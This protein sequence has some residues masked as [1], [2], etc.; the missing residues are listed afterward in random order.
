MVF[1]EKEHLKGDI[2]GGINAGIVALPAALGF[3]ALA[4]L[5]PIHGLYC[6]IF[7]GLFAAI[8]GGTKTLISNPTGPMAVVTYG[9][10]VQ[11]GLM[12]DIPESTTALDKIDIIWPYLFFVFFIAGG[13]QLLFSF[14]KLGKYISYIPTPVV[15]GFMSGIGIIIIVSQIPKALG[16]TLPVRG[17]GGILM[18]L[19]NLILDADI[20]TV[21]IALS[22][23]AIIYLFPKITKKVPGPLVAIVIVT[24]AVYFI[25]VDTD[26]YLIPPIPQQLPNALLQGTLFE[27]F[28]SLF[29]G[30]GKEGMLMFVILSGLT[31]SIIG[32]IDALL[33]AVVSDQ[34]TKT[35]HNSNRELLGQGVGNMVSAMFGGM[36][37]AGTTPATV[38]NIKSGGRS[39]MSGIIHAVLLIAILL[40]AAP[41][42][43]MIPKAALAGLL[44]TVGISILDFDVFKVIKKLPLQDNYVMFMVLGMTAFWDLMYAV[45]AGL[46]FAALVF[47]KK[48]ADAVEIDTRNSKVDRLVDQLVDSFSDS[49]EFRKHVHIKNIKGPMFF[50]FASRFQ[51][52]IEEVGDVK[53]V[54]LN[55]GASTYM[56]QSGVYTLRE[57]IQRLKDKNVTVVL[58]EVKEHAMGLLR[59][60]GVVPQLVDENHV[61]SSV[62]ECVMWLRE[63]GHL[64][65]VFEDDGKLYIPPAYTPNGDGINDEW[66]IRHI[67]K[68]PTCIVDIYTREQKHVFSSKGY[69]EMWEGE[70]EGKTLPS[71]TYHYVIDLYGDG[72]DVR[73]G[74]V[75][76]FR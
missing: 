12:L 43:S 21:V 11:L 41:V 48:M 62:E 65:D 22:T 26:K 61:F 39:R 63:P 35:K 5:S 69:K 33:T 55:L 29:F 10:T 9:L 56:D 19:P 45:A 53:A 38:L 3:G 59:G 14:L 24:V 4:G 23:I 51:D 47:M 15:S 13:F 6:A 37:G 60:V 58:S 44:I 50:G 57:S 52:S 7:L 36:M 49:E 42:A 16:S 30:P 34:L 68:Y 75:S 64:E 31:L 54:L 25:G 72:K 74:D 40:I 70:F 46:I 20:L 17:T 76:V 66:E 8:F 73:K 67:D 32:V 18:A 2:F 1:F 71:D 27:N 28:N